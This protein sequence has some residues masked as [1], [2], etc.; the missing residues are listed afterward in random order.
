MSKF[1]KNGANLKGAKLKKWVEAEVPDVTPTVPP[2]T[3]QKE[4]QTKAKPKT[5]GKKRT[6]K[7]T[8]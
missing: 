7:V 6:R 8:K 5:Q 1:N 3:E 4:P 2:D